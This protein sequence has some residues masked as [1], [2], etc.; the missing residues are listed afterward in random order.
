MLLI[1]EDQYQSLLKPK[2]ELEQAASELV[3]ATDSKMSEP[4]KRLAIQRKSQNYHRVLKKQK[5]KNANEFSTMLK[6]ILQTLQK[7][8]NDRPTQTDMVVKG[9][10]IAPKVAPRPIIK[11]SKYKVKKTPYMLR[12]RKRIIKKPNYFANFPASPSSL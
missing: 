8:K 4:V 6:D 1:P 7:E 11:P 12:K 5:A 9:S 3:D 2:T 10:I